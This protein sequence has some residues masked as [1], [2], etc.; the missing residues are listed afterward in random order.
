MGPLV[1]QDVSL[2]EM[3]VGRD[4]GRKQSLDAGCRGSAGSGSGS[5]RAYRT[6]TLS[7]AGAQEEE[8]GSAVTRTDI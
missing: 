3:A 8:E 1:S 6:D 7:S 4:R 5:G 2:G